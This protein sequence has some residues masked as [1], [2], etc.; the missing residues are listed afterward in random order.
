MQLPHRG[1]LRDRHV[2]EHAEP[3]D[4]HAAQQDRAHPRLRGVRQQVEG[5]L[6]RQ[7]GQVRRAARPRRQEPGREQPEQGADERGRRA[8]REAVR[9]VEDDEHDGRRRHQGHRQRGLALEQ[10]RQHERADD[11]HRDAEPE[12]RREPPPPGHRDH[13]HREHRGEQAE[14]RPADE[15]R[16]DEARLRGPHG[17]QVGGDHPVP[18][19][20]LGQV[21]RWDL[22]PGAGPVGHRRADLA[23]R[24]RGVREH[25]HHRH[26]REGHARRR[27]LQHGPLPRRP[28][29]PRAHQRDQE[30]GDQDRR[31]HPACVPTD[32]RRGRDDVVGVRTHRPRIRRRTPGHGPDTPSH[33]VPSGSA[34]AG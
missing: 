1:R 18:R 19:I 17:S 27:R 12:Q 11:A 30:R 32:L 15:V 8:Q 23:Q 9:Q 13:Q 31:E 24:V 10:R 29:H 21:L 4:D 5:V 20:D 16:E 22:D 28:Q 33:P 3:G 25:L 2:V 7:P 26:R 14:R 6:P 34:L